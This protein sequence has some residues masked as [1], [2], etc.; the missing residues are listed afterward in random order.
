M[1]AHPSTDDISNNLVTRQ[2]TSS[3]SLIFFSVHKRPPSKQPARVYLERL[4]AGSKRA[5][6][7]ALI[8]L[9]QL[10]VSEQIITEE[11]IYTFPW[12]VLRFEHT[13]VLRARLTE[14]YK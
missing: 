5:M 9:V 6:K 12:E 11:D 13:S 7:Q 10:M 3:S 2:D 4:A 8:T 1:S 14:R